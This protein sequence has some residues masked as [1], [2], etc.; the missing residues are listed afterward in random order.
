MQTA[1]LFL[2]SPPPRSLRD[3]SRHVFADLRLAGKMAPRPLI[4]SLLLIAKP[5]L[6]PAIISLSTLSL[7][8]SAALSLLSLGPISLSAP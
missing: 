6:R 2:I 1:R 4:S 5:L 3:V 7:L 8:A